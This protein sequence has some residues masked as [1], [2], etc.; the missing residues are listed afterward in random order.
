VNKILVIAR[1]EYRSTIRTKS[2]MI[3]IVMMPMLMFG[4]IAVQKFTKGKIDTETKRVAV[5]DH[6][7]KM[8][9]ILDKA[10]EYRNSG[11][12]RYSIHDSS[13][14]QVKS[15]YE[16][17]A[18]KLKSTE[19]DAQRLE[20][21]DLVRDQ[22]YFAFIE[23]GSDA[24]DHTGNGDSRIHYYSD[25]P[26]YDEI[27]DWLEFVVNDRV[28]EKRLATA[29]LDSKVV[30]HALEPIPVDNLGLMPRSADGKAV[31][32]KRVD[33]MQTFMI[34]FGMLMLMWIAITM[35][36]QPLLQGVIEEKMQKISEVLLG[37]VRPFDLMMGKL[38]GFV[39]VAI[40]LVAIYLLGG[41]G[42]ARHNGYGDI[43]PFNLLGWFIVFQ[44]LAILMYGSL[45][46]AV[47]SCCSDIREAQNLVMPIFLILMIP[48]FTLNVV[49]QFPSSPA[50][51]MLSLFPPATP[52]LMM[53]RLAI[54]PSPP[55]WQP[56]AG[57]AGSLSMTLVCV[58]A[59]GRIFRI[60]LLL[61]GKAPKMGELVRWVIRG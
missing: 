15:R 27:S 61:Q 30:M 42:L 20:L 44:S 48:F 16:F 39:A 13:G 29:G 8:L 14:R 26:T 11:T 43:I 9:E 4:S 10:T 54:P 49:M 32:A 2:F 40:T 12:D 31:A 1:R 18:V 19:P 38:L 53:I 23:V 60:G 22:Q 7:G 21:S 25:Q 5:L 57:I 28:R 59:A 17:L 37:S 33:R 36:T 51:T 56:L 58:W 35:T 6:S 50:A 47:G 52:M 34:P 45:F 41:Y 46:L 3:A 24:I 55:L